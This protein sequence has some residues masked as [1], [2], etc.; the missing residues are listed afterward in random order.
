MKS[1]VTVLGLAVIVFIS[2][3]AL[4]CGP[5][6]DDAYLVRGSEQE[7]LSMPEGDFKYELEKI[8]GK[9]GQ[10]SSNDK[11]TWGNT[12]AEYDTLRTRTADA[13]ISDLKEALGL[14]VMSEKQKE[15]AITAY[16]ELRSEITEYLRGYVP[17][18]P[19]IWYGDQFRSEKRCGKD[20]DV[21]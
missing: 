10:P 1:K 9:K 2:G 3:S 7:F 20:K 11:I 6:F 8:S 13:D 17:T 4:A 16:T 5:F 19:W 21:A 14:V 15:R 18:N 12:K